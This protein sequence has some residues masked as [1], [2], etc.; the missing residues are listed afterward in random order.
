MFGS[1]NADP[2]IDT[3]RSTFK[4]VDDSYFASTSA[5]RKKENSS[6]IGLNQFT[7]SHGVT[8]RLENGRILQH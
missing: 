6:F 2:L 4:E 8:V 7:P 5:T 3:A 1:K